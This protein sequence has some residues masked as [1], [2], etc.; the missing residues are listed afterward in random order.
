MRSRIACFLAIFFS[1]IIEIMKAHKGFTLIELLV[2]IS[3]IALLSS[4]VLASL[5]TARTKAATGAGLQFAANIEHASGDFAV[6]QWDL[7]ECSGTTF[8]DRSG[9]GNNGAV[10]TATWSTDTPTGRGCSLSLAGSG[11]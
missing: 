1:D 3:I 5:N 11:Q 4:V 2:V 7:D 6:G 10:N 8:A 9:Y